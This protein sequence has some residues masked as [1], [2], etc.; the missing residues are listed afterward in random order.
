MA[1]KKPVKYKQH[2]IVSGMSVS[3]ILNIDN[4]TFNNLG[5]KDMRLVVGRLVS[6][7]NKRMRRME[8]KGQASPAYLK[9]IE[10]GGRFSTKGKTLNEL[11]Q[12][13]ARAREFL[14]QKS[15]SLSGWK[16]LKK[17]TQKKLK[18]QFGIEISTDR[19]EQIFAVYERLKEIDPN[20][21]MNS[22]KYT[23]IEEIDKLS[24]KEFDSEKVLQEMQDK[25]TELYERKEAARY[26]NDG[27]SAFFEMEGDL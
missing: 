5:L 3:D 1:R 11:R 9:A 18:E 4:D 20:M 14:K 17:S 6:A 8:E 19:L 2:S 23:V 16:E 10:T 13:Y 26:D 22:L 12:E 21:A 7:G 24:Q 25:L 15:S 27:P